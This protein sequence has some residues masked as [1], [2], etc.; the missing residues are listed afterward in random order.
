MIGSNA[1]RLRKN[2]WYDIKMWVKMN[3]VNQANGRFKLWVN[4]VLR[5]DANGSD[6]LV[7]NA[8]GSLV[9]D[10][11]LGANAIRYS[12]VSTIQ[13]NRVWPDMF[14]GGDEL[15]PNDSYIH[16]DDMRADNVGIP[17]K[18]VAGNAAPIPVPVGGLQSRM[19]R[20]R[21]TRRRLSGTTLTN[22]HL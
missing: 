18:P 20:I 16:L 8:S 14:Y 7:Y 15:V 1:P 9:Q 6:L 17:L 4:D 22:L 5:V 3:T 19:P 13:I 11:D 12:D 21:S 10:I 2:Q